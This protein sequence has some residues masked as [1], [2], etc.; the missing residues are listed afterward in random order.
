MGQISL[1]LGIH[2][3]Q[4]A[5]GYFLSQAHYAA[6]ML[7]DAGFLDCKLASTPSTPTLKAHSDNSQLFNNPSLYRRLAGSLQY[8][9]ITRPDIAFATNKVCQHMQSPTIQ[10]YDNLTRVLRYIKG[11]ISFGLPIKTGELHLHTYTDAD[12]ASDHMD[13]KSTTGFCSFL[14]PNLVSWSIKKQPTVAKSSTEAEYRSLAAATSDVVWLRRL[15]SELH[16]EQQSPTTIHCDNISAI[17]LAKNP[18][19]H[20]RTKHIEIDYQFIRQHIHTGNIL[21]QHTSSK[22]QVAD[23]LTKSFNT[24]RF[25]E[26]RS[27]LTIQNQND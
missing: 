25:Q 7:K 22:D 26:L 21:L 27:K 14:R 11:T 19:F 20:A 5:Q 2:I 8:L 12:W 4:N 18:V 10:D 13:R 15:V 9:T 17:A 3:H 6:K 23:I 1:F 16:T 24:A